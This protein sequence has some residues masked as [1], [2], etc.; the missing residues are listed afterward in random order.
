LEQ[1]D[2][3][4]L[5]QGRLPR[6]FCTVA[7]QRIAYAQ[8]G[9]GPTVLLLHGLGGT[10]DVWQPLIAVLQERF[11]LLCPDLL[12]FGFS[13]KPD[14]DY[15]PACHARSIAGVL[16]AAGAT[17][18]SALIAHSVGGV[19]AVTLLARQLARAERLVLAAAPYPS[20]RFPVR[21]ELLRRPGDRAMLAWK[22]LAQGVH[23]LLQL[24]WPLL[25][26]VAT[27]AALR[28]AWSGYMDHTIHSYTST[29]EECLFRANLDPLLPQLQDCTTL[30]LYSRAD[31]TVPLVHGE[32]LH[33]ALPRS[34]L[35]L[36]EGDHF[37]VLRS[38]TATVVQWLD[39]NDSDP[40]ADTQLPQQAG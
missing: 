15:T 18:V 27:P 31:R 12:G 39:A 24:L 14:L 6:R 34:T 21:R 17:H 38:G 25:R 40:C 26:Q 11:Q 13:D 3:V 37:A 33:A 35:R 20:P 32:R 29:A 1:R 22:P 30:L 28:G 36:L 8:V 23:Q 19:V 5:V 2:T 16:D 7:G 4:Q 10:A 9:Q